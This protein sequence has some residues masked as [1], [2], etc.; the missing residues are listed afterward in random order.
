MHVAPRRPSALAFVLIAFALAGFSY[1]AVYVWARA[2]H[3][4]VNY[5]S[6]IARPHAG[7]GIGWSDWELA[8]FPLTMA[9]STIRNLG[10]G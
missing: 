7:S 4:L 5:G 8:F 2:T 6:F 10:S 1:C 9:E 3:R